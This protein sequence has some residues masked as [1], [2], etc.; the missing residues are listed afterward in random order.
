MN[1]HTAPIGFVTRPPSTALTP[2]VSHYWLSVDNSDSTHTIVPDGCVDIVFEV[3]ET[4]WRGHVYGTTTRPTATTC[5]PSNH[6]LGVRF[7]PAQSRHFLRA[8]AHE[9]T[10]CR[11]DL[12]GLVRFPAD[13]ISAPIATEALFSQFDRVLMALLR[14]SPPEVTYIDHAVRYVEAMHGVVR[15]SDMASRF[16]KSRRQLERLFL[17][18]VGIPSKFFSLIVRLNRATNL[19]TS[20]PR[21]ALADIATES[22]YSDQSHMT[23]DFAR[24]TGISPGQLMRDDVAFIQDAPI[25]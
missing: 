18:T 1:Q 2:F 10:D 23:R 5:S 13:V 16:G 15:M 6:Y 9:L 12:Q 3:S 19:I 24:L 25:P 21:R 8:T 14:K 7:R 22:G 17:E 11:D 4:G 20:Q